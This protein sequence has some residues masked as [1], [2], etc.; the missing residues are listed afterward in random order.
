[1]ADRFVTNIGGN[2]KVG[3]AIGQSNAPVNVSMNES[4]NPDRQKL[5]DA[6]EHLR[7]AIAQAR[8]AGQLTAEEATIAEYERSNAANEVD[9]AVSGKKV[10]LLGT[11][12]RLMKVARTCSASC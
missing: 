3:A 9:E 1:M 8:Q 7:V 4:E 2:A 10:G 11:L 6:L 12:Q 5:V